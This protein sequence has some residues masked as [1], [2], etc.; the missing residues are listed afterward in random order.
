MRVSGSRSRA[1]TRMTKPSK[2]YWS[3]PIKYGSLSLYGPVKQREGVYYHPLGIVA[4]YQWNNVV[5]LDV[6]HNHR[7]YCMSVEGLFNFIQV[8]TMCRIF[9]LEVITGKISE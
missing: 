1:L 6:C 9:L 3:F 2:K 7:H 4:V 8:R 5:S